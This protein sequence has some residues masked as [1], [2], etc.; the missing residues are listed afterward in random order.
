ML[1]QA[2]M[3]QAEA[4]SVQAQ[5]ALLQAENE[6][7]RIGVFRKLTDVLEKAIEKMK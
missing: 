6:K 3:K 4:A 7:E 5:A 2:T 1:A